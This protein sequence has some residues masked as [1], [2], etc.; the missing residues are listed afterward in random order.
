MITQPAYQGKHRT[1]SPVDLHR[2]AEVKAHY[3]AAAMS[4]LGVLHIALADAA[5]GNIISARFDAA[6]QA[7][8]AAA[9]PVASWADSQIEPL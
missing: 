8:L 9:L 6:G 7:V 2:P 4:P 5:T 1:S 3:T